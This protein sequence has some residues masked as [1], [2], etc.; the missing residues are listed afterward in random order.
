MCQMQHA[1]SNFYTRQRIE[2]AH[3]GL[4]ARGAA[5][6]NTV[7]GY[8]RRPTVPATETEPAKGPFYD[9]IDEE[10]AVVIREVFERI[11]AGETAARGGR[12]ARLDQVR[13]GQVVSAGQV[14]R[15]QRQLDHPPDDLP[16]LRDLPQEGGE[17]E[18]ADRQVGVRL[19]RRGQDRRLGRARTCGSCPMR[20]GIRPTRWWTSR[21]VF[22]KPVR[23]AG[24]PLRGTTRQRRGLLS[25]VFVCG[26]CG[27]ADV[28]LR[29]DGRQLP[30][31]GGGEGQ[32]LEPRLLHA[33]AGLAGGAR[34][35][36][37]RGALARRASATRCW[38]AFGSSMR[39]AAA[40]AAE[41]K[42]LEKDEKRLVA[43]I[44][45][46]SAAVEEGDGALVVARRRGWRTVSGSWRSCGRSRQEVEEQ[47]GR[48]DQAAVGGEA[49]R[50]S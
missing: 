44:E 4:W 38:P 41:L 39:R 49:A 29:E 31:L 5:V 26:I 10:K 18:A 48:K 11:A 30:L 36:G 2:R 16:R 15:R 21:R 43:A 32:M 23:G 28:F 17:A 14:D 33:G 37:Q 7:I 34:G 47:A 24:H 12:V 45:R 50:A 27:S 1:R 40:V 3:D 19:E 20:S 13:Q 22:K 25:G 6:G 8:K 35:R 9:E 46:L 42:R